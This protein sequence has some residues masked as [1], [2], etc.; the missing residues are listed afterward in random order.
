[1]RGAAED[2]RVQG[3]DDVLV[4][5]I[6]CA[7]AVAAAMRKQAGLVDIKAVRGRDVRMNINDHEDSYYSGCRRIIAQA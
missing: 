2:G 7:A 5:R 1:M 3:F 4:R 6:H